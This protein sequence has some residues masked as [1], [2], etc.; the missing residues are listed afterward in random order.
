MKTA[1]VYDWLCSWGGA[2]RTLLELNKIFPKAPIYTSIY[3]PKKA[4]FA[5]EFPKIKTTFLQKLSFLNHRLLAPLMPMAFEN[6]DFSDFDLIIS[7]TSFAAK[8][9][10]VRPPTK[11]ICYLLTPTRFLWYP[12][13]YSGANFPKLIKNYLKSW[14]LIASQRPDQIVAISKTVQD[15]CQ[16]I[17]QRKS[18]IIYPPIDTKLF[19]PGKTKSCISAERGFFLIVSRLE[20]QKKIDLAIEVFNDLGWPLKII[21]TGSWERK[22][23]NLARKNIEF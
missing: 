14:D 19:S 17:Y 5:Q 12:K 13:Q 16:K 23:K 10:I 21:G 6:F 9:I 11:H 20:R 1:L 8:G 15:R 22:L 18:S 2:E 3:K 4:S 7:V